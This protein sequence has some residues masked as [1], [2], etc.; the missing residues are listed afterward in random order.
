MAE[1]CKV[2]PWGQARHCCCTASALLCLHVTG[3]QAVWHEA[4]LWPLVWPIGETMGW[5]QAGCLDG[6]PSGQVYVAVPPTVPP[7]VSLLWPALLHPISALVKCLVLKTYT[8][9]EITLFAVLL[10]LSCASPLDL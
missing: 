4:T 1:E 3:E 2:P 5:C 6:W 9:I 8:A 10:H 7:T